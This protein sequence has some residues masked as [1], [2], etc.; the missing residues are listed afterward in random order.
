[1]MQ[2]VW[3]PQLDGLFVCK[4]NCKIHHWGQPRHQCHPPEEHDR[5]V[6]AELPMP[7]LKIVMTNSENQINTRY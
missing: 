3:H 4:P 7:E 2:T 5:D 1:M 6:Y